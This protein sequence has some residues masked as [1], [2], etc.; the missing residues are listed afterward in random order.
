MGRQQPRFP[1]IDAQKIEFPVRSGQSHRLAG[2][3]Q[4]GGVAGA[5]GETEKRGAKSEEGQGGKELHR[6]EYSAGVF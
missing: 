5:G 6:E 4:I 1:C 3:Q 2:D